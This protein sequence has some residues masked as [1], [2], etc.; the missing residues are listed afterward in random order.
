MDKVARVNLSK[1][2]AEKLKNNIT[3][4]K[5]KPGNQL[6][7]YEKLCEKWGVSRVTLRE[8]LKKLETEGIVEIHQRRETLENLCNAKES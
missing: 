8:A 7:T 5:F 2:I 4:G 1:L 3:K 6:P